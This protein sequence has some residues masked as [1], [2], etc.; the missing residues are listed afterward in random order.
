MV[1]EVNGFICKQSLHPFMLTFKV[2]HGVKAIKEEHMAI[3]TTLPKVYDYPPSHEA[4]RPINHKA[5]QTI[6]KS[7]NGY[8]LQIKRHHVMFTEG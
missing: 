3:E 2:Q 8:K 5:L 1:Q 4:Q 7:L 6:K